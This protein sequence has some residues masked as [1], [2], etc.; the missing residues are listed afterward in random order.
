MEKRIKFR[1]ND[2][3]NAFLENRSLRIYRRAV[4]GRLGFTGLS[5]MVIEIAGHEPKQDE[6]YGFYVKN[7]D[8]VKILKKDTFSANILEFRDRQAKELKEYFFNL[9]CLS[10]G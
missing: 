6:C 4:D 7:G 2:L 9:G 5:K 3:L 10:E 8:V 1:N